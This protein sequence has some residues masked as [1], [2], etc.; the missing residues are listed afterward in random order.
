MVGN[1]NRTVVSWI[2]QRRY[3]VLLCILVLICLSTPA[4]VFGQSLT[5]TFGGKGTGRAVA[6]SHQGEPRNDWAGTLKLKLDSGE[7]LIVFCIEIGVRVRAG[8]RYRSDGPVLALPNGCQIRYL[9]DHYPGST[10]ATADEAAARQMAVWVFS[11][12]VDPTTIADATVRERTIALVNEA[13]NGP[14]PLRRTEAPALTLQPPTASTTI[15]QTIA[16]TIRT[17]TDDGGQTVTVAVSGPAV[18]ADANGSSSGKQ[19]QSVILDAQGTGTF[20]ATSTG[21][22]QTTIN[23][24][25]PYRLEAGTVFSHLDD[26][27]P[28]QR[29]VMAENRDLVAKAS[30]QMSTSGE[31]LSPTATQSSQQPTSV[32]SQPTAVAPQPTS[33]SS[34]PTAVAP[35]PTSVP[36]QPT[37]QPEQPLATVIAGVVASQPTPAA[38]A[39]AQPAPPGPSAGG[40]VAQ[41]LAEAPAGVVVPRSLPRTGEPEGSVSLPLLVIVALLL[42]GGWLIRRRALR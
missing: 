42:S 20:W 2:M 8:D 3:R 38:K 7:D 30:A 6:F 41:P 4:V 12:G 26:D 34:Q 1:N 19:E 28:S 25:L 23:V 18:L 33:V 27:A 17:G 15:G 32:P 13:K 11:D 35:Q 9:L 24:T 21:A 37:N 5:G 14:C 39:T 22:G 36:S 29:L 10:A 16:Y 31:V 40:S